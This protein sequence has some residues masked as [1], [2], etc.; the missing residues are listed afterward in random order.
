MYRLTRSTRV[1]EGKDDRLTTLLSP[2]TRMMSTIQQCSCYGK[3]Q[4]INYCPLSLDL[5]LLRTLLWRSD[6]YY[7]GLGREGTDPANS[8]SPRPAVRGKDGPRSFLSPRPVDKVTVPTNMC[9]VTVMTVYVCLPES[10][11]CKWQADTVNRGCVKLV[12][13]NNSVNMFALFMILASI[14]LKCDV[15]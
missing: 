13:V 2:Q 1:L 8:S 11:R 9:L 14:E 15:P 6:W 3:F 7:Q 5:Y 10:C 12:A 4:H